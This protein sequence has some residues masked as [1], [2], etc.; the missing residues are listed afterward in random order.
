M[1]LKTARPSTGGTL[2]LPQYDPKVKPLVF[3][4]GSLVTLGRRAID[5][6]AAGAD[7]VAVPEFESVAAA[8]ASDR[9]AEVTSVAARRWAAEGASYHELVRICARYVMELDK[10]V[11]VCEPV[12]V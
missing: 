8:I 10:V 9:R 4:I 3:G 6:A 12:Y 7:T 5:A 11:P 2:N 1:V